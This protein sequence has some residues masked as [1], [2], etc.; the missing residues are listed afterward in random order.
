M[1]SVIIIVSQ[2]SRFWQLNPSKL[3]RLLSPDIIMQIV[4]MYGKKE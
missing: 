2:Q 1:I 4:T 3:R